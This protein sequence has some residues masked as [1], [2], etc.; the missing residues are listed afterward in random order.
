M[1]QPKIPK[2]VLTATWLARMPT[3]PDKANSNVV[4]MLKLVHAMLLS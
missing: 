1:I 3:L 4:K 2:I